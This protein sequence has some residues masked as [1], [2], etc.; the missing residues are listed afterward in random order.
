MAGTKGHSGR[1]P[2]PTELLKLRGTYRADRHSRN[3]PKPETTL[4]DRP[5]WLAGE[6]KKEWERLSPVLVR[7]GLLSE[8]DR[9]CFASYCQ[10]WAEFVLI[11]RK[12]R[13]LEDFTVTT[14][15]G[16]VIQHPL[17]GIR[18]RAHARLLSALREFGLTPSAR[19]GLSLTPV[20]SEDDPLQE[21]IDRKKRFFNKRTPSR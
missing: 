11:S 10:A 19:A 9:A 12:V 15:K 13:R 20:S 8:L 16:N 17:L 7:H 5:R 3:R 18:N 1:R 6:G 2:D 21:L 4:P 14:D